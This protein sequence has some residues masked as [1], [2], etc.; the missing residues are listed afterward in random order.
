MKLTYRNI[1]LSFMNTSMAF[2]F[3]NTKDITI[4]K[5]APNLHKNYEEHYSKNVLS[6]SYWGKGNILK[7][8]LP[9]EESAAYWLCHFFIISSTTFCTL[10]NYCLVCGLG[11]I[12]V[13]I[14]LQATKKG[15][16]HWVIQIKCF[17]K[18]DYRRGWKII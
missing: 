5:S 18:C 10:T 16:A 11:P 3:E 13:I 14:N 9:S 6:K 12:L 17:R 2:M 4:K 7:Q 8:M 15:G 1:G